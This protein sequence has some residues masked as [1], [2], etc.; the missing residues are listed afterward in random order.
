VGTARFIRAAAVHS[1]SPRAAMIWIIG[2]DNQVYRLNGPNDGCGW[3]WHGRAH[4]R[5]ANGSPGW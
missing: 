3:K 2:T 4:R 5:G 1:I